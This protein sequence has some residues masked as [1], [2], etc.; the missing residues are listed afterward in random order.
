MS[1]SVVALRQMVKL[2][3]VLIVLEVCGVDDE[4][5]S[6]DQCLNIYPYHQRLSH[7]CCTRSA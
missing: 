1:E 4:L 6:L 5:C 3:D 2:I 7:L